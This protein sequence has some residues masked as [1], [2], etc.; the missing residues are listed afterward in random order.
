MLSAETVTTYSDRRTRCLETAQGSGRRH[1]VDTAVQSRDA[2]YRI[3]N[4]LQN[5]VSS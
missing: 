5:V 1:G 4:I 3:R 2:D